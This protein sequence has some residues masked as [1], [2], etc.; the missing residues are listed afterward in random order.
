MFR[1]QLKITCHTK[2]QDNIKLNQKRQSTDA[3]TEMTQML[4]LSDKD[5]KGAI[6]KCFNKQLRTRFKQMK[7]LSA[8]KPKI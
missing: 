3:N 2:S 8:K 4:E 7:K 1:M 5:L 6:M